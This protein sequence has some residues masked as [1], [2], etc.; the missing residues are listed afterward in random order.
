MGCCDH[1]TRTD[2]WRFATDRPVNCTVVQWPL[3][4]TIAMVLALMLIAVLA[5]DGWIG[6]RD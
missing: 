2:D 5:Y 3:T 4:Y 6:R 1:L